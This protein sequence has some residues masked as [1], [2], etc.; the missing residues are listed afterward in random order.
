MIAILMTVRT[1]PGKAGRFAGLIEQLRADVH[2]N[3]PDTLVFEILHDRAD[4][5]VFH[6]IEVFASEDAKERHAEAPYH[7]AMS[8]AGW[9][10]VDGEP[11]IRVCDPVGVL[12]RRGEMS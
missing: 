1:Q 9:S 6:F 10:C 5:A 11:E 7:K 2:A 12:K 4:P 3:E 8:E